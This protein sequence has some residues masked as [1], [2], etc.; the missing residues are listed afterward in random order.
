M[1]IK[2][3]WSKRELI[4]Q[5]DSS[6]YERYM[7]AD[8]PE[9]VTAL[10]P[11]QKKDELAKHFKDEYILE[12]LDL[13]KNYSEKE[14]QNSILENLKSFFLEFGKDFTFVGQEYPIRLGNKEYRVDLL[15]FHRS[16]KCLVAVEL[17]VTEFKPEYIGKMQFYLNLLDGKVRNT[18]EN[19]SIGLI[20]CKSK[21][22]DE[23]K[24]AL[25]KTVSPIKV[26]TYTKK[27]PDKKLILKRLEN[28]KIPESTKDIGSDLT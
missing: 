13:G 11:Q 3:K 1:S 15:F 18:N 10:I 14:L 2:E 20:L 4:R 27:L 25:A 9:K 23:V 8:K 16:L 6:L 22:H 24:F 19:P 7:L 5:I 21:E 26:A 28:I 17:K 12:F